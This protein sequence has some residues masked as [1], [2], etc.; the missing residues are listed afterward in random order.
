MLTSSRPVVP[1]YYSKKPPLQDSER[2]RESYS[3]ATVSFS[4]RPNYGVG[5][6]QRD[7]LWLAFMPFQYIGV[8]VERLIHC[9][10]VLKW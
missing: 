5:N 4:Q 8:R 2:C 10:P 7:S 1:K 3:T 9:Y 6:V